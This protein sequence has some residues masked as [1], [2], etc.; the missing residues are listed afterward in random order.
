[1]I[2]MWGTFSGHVESRTRL[3]VLRHMVWKM[4]YA[5]LAMTMVS[6]ID[7][8]YVVVVCFGCVWIGEGQEW[9]GERAL[10]GDLERGA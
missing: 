10:L 3:R 6:D 8:A 1:M 4:N 9:G 7:E 5:R 2:T